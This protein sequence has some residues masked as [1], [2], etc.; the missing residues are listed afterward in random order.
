M[1]QRIQSIY[2]LL[3]SIV[4]IISIFFPIARMVANGEEVAV[5]TN[6]YLTT[7]K[8]CSYNFV[9]LLIIVVGLCV[10]LFYT[11]FIY[12]KRLTQILFCKVAIITYFVYYIVFAIASF[13]M[14]GKTD[15]SYALTLG[16]ACPLISLILTVL[17]K[18]AISKD[19]KMVRAA[20]RIR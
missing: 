16:A 10:I 18:Q 13:M 4:L 15:G 19:E 3:A 11:I 1:I 2:L 5:L 6:L 7:G 9:W 17:A 20:D 12:K 14:M 8:T